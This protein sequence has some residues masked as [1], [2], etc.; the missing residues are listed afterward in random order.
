[1]VPEEFQWK[2]WGVSCRWTWIIANSVRRHLP[3]ILWIHRSQHLRS[4]LLTSPLA[5]TWLMTLIWRCIFNNHNTFSIFLWSIKEL[6]PSRDNFQVGTKVHSV[7][8]CALHIAHYPT[9][10]PIII[11]HVDA[12]E[13]GWARA[14]SVWSSS[15]RSPRWRT[16]R[17]ART[18]S[19]GQAAA[20]RGTGAG[21]GR[22]RRRG[23][24]SSLD[25]LC[26]SLH[27]APGDT[28]DTAVTLP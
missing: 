16:S 26:T 8:S 20:S 12:R 27:P 2:N 17:T 1:M 25:Y 5:S 13:R 9:L 19:G 23:T 28:A 15:R 24:L 18:G 22:C 11:D 6:V 21:A 14:A 7:H 10:Q 4:L 3:Q